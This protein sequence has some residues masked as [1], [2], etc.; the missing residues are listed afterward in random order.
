[1]KV[2]VT[3][4]ISMLLVACGGNDKVM[5]IGVLK[6]YALKFQVKTNH[7]SLNFT[8]PALPPD[9]ENVVKHRIIDDEYKLYVSLILARHY[10]SH[11]TIA[12]QSY[13]I[14]KDHPLWVAF[15]KYSGIDF[16][17]EYELSNVIYYNWLA[18][19]SSSLDPLFKVEYESIKK[20]LNRVG[21]PTQ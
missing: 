7:A 1:M 18:P 21:N 4:L 8:L 14:V 6:E 15:E 16:Q 5:E 9:V 12:G 10:R 13:L 3:I 20:E 17:S 19:N 11:I 2:I